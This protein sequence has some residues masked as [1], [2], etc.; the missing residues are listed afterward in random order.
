ML[1]ISLF[2]LKA[3]AFSSYHDTKSLQDS[4]NEI[5][6]ERCCCPD[7]IHSSNVFYLKHIPCISSC[8][9]IFVISNEGKFIG[10]SNYQ[11]PSSRFF[12]PSV[13]GMRKFCLLHLPYSVI[14]FFVCLFFLLHALSWVLIHPHSTLIIKKDIT[15]MD[16]F[17]LLLRCLKKKW[18]QKCLIC[19]ILYVPCTKYLDCKWLNMVSLSCEIVP[20]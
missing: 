15:V 16:F 13:W 2:L 14:F 11:L 3:A 12:L 1:P 7:E 6:E 8:W 10:Q 5:I 17:W 4:K 20:R 18:V 19:Q 9:L